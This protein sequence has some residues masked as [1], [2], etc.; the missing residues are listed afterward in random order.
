MTER[1]PATNAFPHQ[2]S[3][4][5][6][7]TLEETSLATHRT[8]LNV[9]TIEPITSES[10]TVSAVPASCERDI[11][12]SQHNPTT[13]PTAIIASTHATRYR[14]AAVQTLPP[15]NAEQFH[16]IYDREP[17]NQELVSKTGSAAIG[18]YEPGLLAN[19]YDVVLCTPFS[20][21]VASNKRANY[22]NSSFQTDAVAQCKKALLRAKVKASMLVNR[23][24][25]AAQS[26]GFRVWSKT[27][28]EH[29]IHSEQFRVS[30]QFD[31]QGNAIK[32]DVDGLSLP[33]IYGKE[34][35]PLPKTIEPL[36]QSHSE[37]S[38]QDAD[39]NESTKHYT[40]SA[41]SA[42]THPQILPSVLP[43]STVEGMSTPQRIRTVEPCIPSGKSD[44]AS[45]EY[46]GYFQL[47]PREAAE[48]D[49]N[50]Y[51]GKDRGQRKTIG[52][53]VGP[54]A[55][56]RA[57]KDRPGKMVKKEE[58]VMVL[59]GPRFADEYI[60]VD[61][62]A[63]TLTNP[64]TTPN[65]RPTTTKK[66]TSEDEMEEQIAT[67]SPKRFKIS[68]KS[69][70]A[71][72]I[73]TD[74]QEDRFVKDKDDSVMRDN[75]KAT[76]IERTKHKEDSR[77]AAGQQA[78]ASTLHKRC[79]DEPGTEDERCPRSSPA[80]QDC[81]RQSR[82]P[83]GRH[84]SSRCRSRSTARRGSERT[85][86]EKRRLHK[87]ASEIDNDSRTHG[88]INPAY[89]D[90]LG[91]WIED[92]KSDGQKKDADEIVSVRKMSPRLRLER[93]QRVEE[94]KLAKGH[95][96]EGAEIQRAREAKNRRNSEIEEKKQAQEADRQHRQEERDRDQR[97][98]RGDTQDRSRKESRQTMKQERELS[99]VV[100]AYALE[101][102]AE[103]RRRE[104]VFTAR[105]TGEADS[106]APEKPSAG[107]DSFGRTEVE[108]AKPEKKVQAGRVTKPRPSRTV[109]GE[110]ERYD[111][112]KKFG[113][114][115]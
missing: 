22:I 47:V 69:V 18:R 103:A 114:G 111:P 4:V 86:E 32:A 34:I 65:M 94:E 106:R 67:T 43:H 57:Q 63:S 101:R 48:K 85:Y 52:L 80:H 89:I 33:N 98:R 76:D 55:A 102:K 78:Q 29:I 3:G 84:I 1:V 59:G 97:R 77:Q 56:T 21:P 40:S 112:K 30:V 6:G 25:D 87:V 27:R 23:Q 41:T 51:G 37:F 19:G 11:A 5:E 74:A 46:Y 66:R 39:I 99:E 79:K 54:H 100:E 91:R 110:L 8:P 81:R 95:K 83:V 35:D 72:E 61:V 20:A 105:G 17:T 64:T 93:G 104:L 45:T 42:I 31:D 24:R 13:Q 96:L 49:G 113:G 68:N 70:N 109:R 88:G 2:D 12:E 92:R 38:Y 82:S 108:R 14:S 36:E 50:E 71:L 26:A 9:V 16:R 115:K 44:P 15:S 7:A 107:N 75:A 10:G 73:G 90:K 58:T 53:D 60:I 28:D 62:T